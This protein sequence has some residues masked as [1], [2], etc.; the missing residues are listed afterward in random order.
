MQDGWACDGSAGGSCVP[1]LGGF[2]T[3]AEC[4]DFCGGS[5]PPSLAP[6]GPPPPPG[7]AAAPPASFE[8]P[9][10][11]ATVYTYYKCAECKPRSGR[12]ISALPS[13]EAT[14]LRTAP[15]ACAV[16][17]LAADT[18]LATS[19]TWPLTW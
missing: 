12:L 1:K 4:N 2:P 11:D 10:V 13:R 19:V 5:T 7:Y 9:G 16:C 3:K 18:R 6:V 14:Q 17:N 8:M 15:G